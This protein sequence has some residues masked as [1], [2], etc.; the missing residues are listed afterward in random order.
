MRCRRRNNRK[1]DGVMRASTGTRV[2][3]SREGRG[4][5]GSGRGTMRAAKVVISHS[6]KDKEKKPPAGLT[7]EAVAARAKRLDVCRKLREELYKKL[8]ADKRFEV[9]LDV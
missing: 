9:F 8:K 6:C 7:K 4:C 1:I 3:D 5:R 2:A